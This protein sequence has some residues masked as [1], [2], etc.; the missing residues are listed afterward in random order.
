MQNFIA[1]GWKIKIL[2][3]SKPLYVTISPFC[4]SVDYIYSDESLLRK[5]RQFST[6]KKNNSMEFNEFFFSCKIELHLYF[7]AFDFSPRAVNFVK[8]TCCIYP[9]SRIQCVVWSMIFGFEKVW[10]TFTF[11]ILIN[12]ILLARYLFSD[13]PNCPRNLLDS[14]WLNL[15]YSVKL[16]SLIEGILA[17]VITMMSYQ[18]QA[19]S[20]MAEWCDHTVGII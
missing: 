8:V 5:V 9:F 13:P 20:A 17:V 7:Y 1:L 18:M 19:R 10:H 4:F 12:N 14:S 2:H 11:K 6:D 15:H 3:M 16:D